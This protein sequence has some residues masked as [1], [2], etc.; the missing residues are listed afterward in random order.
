M[1]AVLA[2]CGGRVETKAPVGEPPS[3]EQL[4]NATYYGLQL[5]GAPVA[6]QDGF[7]ERVRTSVTLAEGFRATGDLTGDGRPDAVV[8]LGESG[9]GSGSFQYLAAVGYRDG[10]LE[11][12][13]TV[14]LGDRVQVR[15]VRIAPGELEADV[16]QAGPG[17]PACCPGELVTRRWRYEPAGLHELPP[18]EAKRFNLAALEGSQWTLHSL[19]AKTPLA[20]ANPVTLTVM[21]TGFSG[22]TGCNNFSAAA[23]SGEMGVLKVKE[24]LASKL[25]CEGDVAA[26]EQQFLAALEKVDSMAFQNGR[27]AL[28]Y[29]DGGDVKTMTFDP[30]QP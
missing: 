11:N 25:P 29:R 12:L 27:L 23:E 1:A 17:D 8:I 15:R 3:W 6:L 10:R 30:V 20:G 16:V 19:D 7:W 28:N 22:S 18:G 4:K 13:A 9:G 24:P 21:E 2:S 14:P 5:P 26:L